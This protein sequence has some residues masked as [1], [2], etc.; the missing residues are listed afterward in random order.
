MNKLDTSFISSS[1]IFLNLFFS[2]TPNIAHTYFQFTLTL[3]SLTSSTTSI[4]LDTSISLLFILFILIWYKEIIIA[5][6]IPIIINILPLFFIVIHH[7]LS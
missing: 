5:A 6:I 1:D 3:F 7:F 4:N 2:F